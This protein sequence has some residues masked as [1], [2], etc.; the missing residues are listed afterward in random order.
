MDLLSLR[1]I[2]LQNYSSFINFILK[3]QEILSKI[4]K[5]LH[6]I[7]YQLKY[8]YYSWIIKKVIFYYLNFEQFRGLDG[9][10]FYLA[11]NP[12]GIKWFEISFFSEKQRSDLRERKKKNLLRNVSIIST[13]HI[14]Q[15]TTRKYSQLKFNTESGNTTK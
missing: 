9:V 15:Q 6:S 12:I 5:I 13:K 2:F 3:S 4:L 1:R 14:V 11:S 10:V 8:F 7:I